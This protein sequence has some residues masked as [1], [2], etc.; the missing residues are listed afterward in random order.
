[1]ILWV[2]SE[3]P[4]AFQT[5][6]DAIEFAEPGDRLIVTGEFEPGTFTGIPAGKGPLLIEAPDYAAD[7]Y[8]DEPVLVES[9]TLFININVYCTPEGALCA[10]DPSMITLDNCMVEGLDNPDDY[11]LEEIDLEGTDL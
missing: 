6:D 11:E 7:V 4:R 5:L 9:P 3:G 10:Q 8:L 2:H 1:M